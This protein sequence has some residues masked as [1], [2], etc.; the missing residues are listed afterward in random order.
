MENDLTTLVRHEFW[1][2]AAGVLVAASVAA[3]ITG[4]GAWGSVL[5]FPPFVRNRLEPL[6]LVAG[7]IALIILPAFL[8]RLATFVGGADAESPPPTSA[9]AATE[10]TS[11]ASQPV[12]EEIAVARL[13]PLHV[14]AS[15]A[16]QLIAAML[17]LV[18][19]ASRFEGGLRGWGLGLR[20]LPRRMGQAFIV[21]VGVWPFCLGVLLVTLLA[22]RWLVPGYAPREHETIRILQSGEMPGWALAAT[23]AGAIV[24]APIYEECFFR[25]LLLP[26][27]TKTTQSTW[28]AIVI[29]GIL[30]GVFHFGLPHTIPALALFGMCLGYAYART[31]SLTLVVLLHAVFNAKTL[32]WLA[33]VH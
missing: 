6:D 12:E 32:I 24:F 21:Y 14:A 30:F 33:L 22:M 19:G 28:L 7:L 16:G 31:R 26:L 8:F 2:L 5:R 25:G 17:L 20:G 9:V 4:R 3:I 23:A 1:L 18:I 13:K 15:A 11:Q 29:S 10:P 27:I